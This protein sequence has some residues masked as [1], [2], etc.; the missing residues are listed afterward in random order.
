M[1]FQ[2][3]EQF[4]EAKTD[5]RVCEDMIVVTD[6]FAAVIDG[7]SDA[8]GA[9]FSGKSGG[10]FAAEVVAGAISALQPSADARTFADALAEA[11]AAAVTAAAGDLGA[12]VRWPVAVLACASAQRREVWRIGD[13]HVVIDGVAYPGA[14]RIGDAACSF[15]AATNAALLGKGMPL[16]E[17]IAN[18]PGATAARLLIDNQQHLAN[19]VAPWGH[20]CINGQRVPDEYIEVLPIPKESTQVILTSDGYPTVLGTLNETETALAEM[21]KQDPLAVGE[22]W[23]MGKPMKPGANAP[24]DRAYLRFRY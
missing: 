15:R 4:V 5:G 22:L 10:R 7:A 9:Q 21:V 17:L 14:R 1:G 24:D 3:L 23:A 12:D 13:G 2:I 6:D 11:A 8:T 19:K 20:G 18:D 16:D